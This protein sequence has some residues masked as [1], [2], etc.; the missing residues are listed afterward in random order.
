MPESSPEA[1]FLERVRGI[2]GTREVPKA[3]RRKPDPDEPW[4]Y[5]C[6]DCGGQ[7]RGDGL[8]YE[9][10]REDCRETY[11]KNDLRDLKKDQ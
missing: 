7:V 11:D 5:V 9:C 3:Y 4:R 10:K 1:D 8:M 2:E 6:P